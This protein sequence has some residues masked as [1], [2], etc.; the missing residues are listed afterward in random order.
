M[1]STNFLLIL[2]IVFLV[3]AAVFAVTIFQDVSWSAKIAFTATGLAAGICL[4]RWIAGSAK[5]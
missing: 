3:L 5:K 1:K 4:G 2:A